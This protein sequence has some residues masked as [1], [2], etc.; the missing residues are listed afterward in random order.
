LLTE[1]ST[2]VVLPSVPFMCAKNEVF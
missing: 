2:K 1:L